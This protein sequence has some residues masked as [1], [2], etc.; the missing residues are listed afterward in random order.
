MGK[1]RKMPLFV[2]AFHRKS[3][4]YKTFGMLSILSVVTVLM[5]AL[6]I[7]QLVVRTQ[8]DRIDDLNLTQLRRIGDD[9][10]TRLQNIAQNM[11]QSLWSS[12]F[13]SLMVNPYNKDSDRSFRIVDQLAGYVTG[14]ALIEQ[15]FLYLPASEEV[16]GSDGNYLPLD[17]FSDQNAI[18]LYL[19]NHDR[20]RKSQGDTEW[21]IFS[22]ED[23]LYVAVDFCVPN[24]IGAIFAQLN[25][26][27]LYTVIQ[28]EG[29]EAVVQVFDGGGNTLFAGKRGQ[30]E[31]VSFEELSGD[32][33]YRYQS[34]VTGWT[35]LLPVG[36]E[37]LTSN[38]LSAVGI[39][40][41]FLLAYALF[42]Q[43]FS[44]YITRSIY[45]PINRLM[46]MTAGHQNLEGMPA[47]KVRNETDY[48]E[49]AYSNL[50]GENMQ[51]RQL[52]QSVSQD[53]MEQMFR[54]I[55]QRKEITKDQIKNTLEGI[56]MSDFITG[57]YLVLA[58]ALVLPKDR[59]L[60]MVET[61]L[62]QRS[63]VGILS[64]MEPKEGRLFPFYM[65]K[66]IL[67][68]ICCFH[69]EISVI[70]VKQQVRELIE[71]VENQTEA[72]PYEVLFGKGKV[73]SD[74]LS[75]SYSFQE[76]VAE[77]RYR[78]YMAED[79][80]NEN[81]VD[82]GQKY[83]RDRG[84][85]IAE[86]VEKSGKDESEK[87]AENLIQEIGEGEEPGDCLPYYELIMEIM[88]EKLAACHVMDGEKKEESFSECPERL[89]QIGNV[90]EMEQ[91]MRDFYRRAIHVIQTGSKKNRYK[92]VEAAK[93]Y[94]ASHYSDGNLS[95]NE[96]SE[97]IGI[98]SPYLSGI[99]TEVN[100]GGFSSYLN[101]F[102]VEQAKQFLKEAEESVAEIGYK[103]G[104]NSAQ[105]FSRVFKKHTGFTPG[106]YRERQKE[107]GEGNSETH[108]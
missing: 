23:Q 103:C 46:Q 54:K 41:P 29:A 93:D 89:R 60:T 74:M 26:D 50:V 49:L 70:Q 95:L 88:L 59:E 105:S 71:R 18:Q 91:F 75:L 81:I 102:R 6:F 11:E 66:D 15:A 72:L 13:I 53:I 43:L 4:F 24:F 55:L 33:W 12:D 10:D 65:E 30:Q 64:E 34:P 80:E 104:F 8:K 7:N 9:V 96:V 107:G 1:N 31:G 83:Y 17:R 76:A 68:V 36:S 16:F 5:F 35:Y 32:N 79:P 22:C 82:F 28:S 61:N 21:K 56:G 40:L 20:E 94:I 48:L 87:A 2:N 98:S 86:M 27:Q 78:R 45:Q 37:G 14:N 42:S 58:G 63:I 77:V 19:D 92:Y 3:I 39:G 51:H 99:F 97:A 108:S 62:Y 38:L 44:V 73:Y 52:M 67:A 100:K 57:R 106:Q 84:T 25:T 69:E 47:D 101:A 90:R 85:Q